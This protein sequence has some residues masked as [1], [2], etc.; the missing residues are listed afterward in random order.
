M[1]MYVAIR[2]CGRPGWEHGWE[3][4]SEWSVKRVKEHRLLG[5]NL[6]YLIEWDGHDDH[7]LPWPDSWEFEASIGSYHINAYTRRLTCISSPRWSLS[8]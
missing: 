4:G 2:A 7:E 5:S 1:Y 8:T 3:V 6:Q